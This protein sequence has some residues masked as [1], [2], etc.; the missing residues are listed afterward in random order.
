MA[1]PPTSLRSCCAEVPDE[2]RLNNRFRYPASCRQTGTTAAAEKTVRWTI[3]ELS[4]RT[5]SCRSATHFTKR[6]FEP[7]LADTV[8]AIGAVVPCRQ[9]P[10]RFPS[11]AWPVAA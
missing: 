6:D 1:S 2:K 11:R 4:T 3:A 9:E 5:A 10:R 7:V 8:V